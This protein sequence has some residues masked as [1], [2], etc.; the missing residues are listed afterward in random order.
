ME[1]I[2]GL[3]GNQ[4]EVE[5]TAV[6]TNTSQSQQPL[7]PPVP[8]KRKVVETR[9]PVWDHFEKIK[10][11]E[12]IVVKG[13]CLYCARVY[14][15]ESKKHETSSLRLHVVNCLKNPHSKDTRQSLLTFQREPSSAGTESSEGS[16][17]V[18]GTWVFDQDLIRRALA[19]MIILDEFPFRI[20]EG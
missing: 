7:P 3:S 14:C 6:E 12:G 18:L 2:S 11:S 13:K 8:K 17:G 15:N 4:P 16:E 1:S 19:E 9:S 5:A 20:V 10:D